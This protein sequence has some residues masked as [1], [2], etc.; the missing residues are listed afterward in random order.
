M[1]KLWQEL[2]ITEKWLILIASVMTL[3]AGIFYG[4]SGFCS[5]VDAACTYKILTVESNNF[6]TLHAPLIKKDSETIEAMRQVLEEI[7]ITR[8]MVTYRM[9]IDEQEQAIHVMEVQDKVRGRKGG[10]R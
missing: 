4:I 8:A 2:K 1:K 10:I 5:K 9:P 6:K 7:K 3:S